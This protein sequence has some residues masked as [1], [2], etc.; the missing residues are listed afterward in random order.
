MNPFEFVNAINQSKRDLMSGTENDELAEKSYVPYVINKTFSYFPDTIFYANELNRNHHIDNKLQFH[1][2]LN[3]IRPQKRFAK[4][5][6]KVDH[7]NLEVIKLYYG[8]NNE[9]ASEALAMLSSEQ[10]Q[11]IKEKLQKGG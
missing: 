4:W 11:F 10:I 7:E 9:K 6:K 1:Y 5:V 2:L 3:S 8:Y